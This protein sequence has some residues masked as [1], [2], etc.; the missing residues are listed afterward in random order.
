M[1]EPLLSGIFLARVLITV[2]SSLLA[3]FVATYP[4]REINELEHYLSYCLEK[5]LRV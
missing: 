1:V 4:K 2:F 3:R 5:H